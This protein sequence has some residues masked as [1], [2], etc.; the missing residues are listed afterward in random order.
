VAVSHLQPGIYGISNHLL[1][2][3]WPKV[4][5]GKLELQKLIDSGAPATPDRLLELLLD[6]AYA[7]DHELPET[8]VGLDLERAL[9]ARFVMT[10]GYGTRS[11]TALLIGR[12]GAISFAERRFGPNGEVT[13]E[14]HFAVAATALPASES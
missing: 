8:G 3:P 6:R 4:V 11:S 14:D 5:R 13:G 1:D 12:D 9:S 2:T 10:P 7:V